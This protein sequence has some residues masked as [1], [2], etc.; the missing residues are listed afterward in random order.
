M[1]LGPFE[2]TSSG[3]GPVAWSC[4]LWWWFL[5]LCGQAGHSWVRREVRSN[6]TCNWNCKGRAEGGAI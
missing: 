3:C 5:T 6:F 1:G 4:G 2:W